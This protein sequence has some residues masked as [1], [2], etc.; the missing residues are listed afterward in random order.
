MWGHLQC[1][2]LYITGTMARTCTIHIYTYT[3]VHACT[4]ILYVSSRNSTCLRQSFNNRLHA[5]VF[6]LSNNQ[7][8]FTI[9]LRL[10]LTHNTLPLCNVY[11]IL[12]SG[13][14]V[15]VGI[16]LSS[17]LQL[18]SGGRPGYVSPPRRHV[19]PPK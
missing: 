4:V 18:T 3:H 11:I 16:Y 15:W 7:Q 12:L 14:Y 17:F 13:I 19:S 10:E 5:P 8:Y 2:R 9:F 6:H 1:S